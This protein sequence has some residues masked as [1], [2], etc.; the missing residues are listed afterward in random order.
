MFKNTIPKRQMHGEEGKNKQ[1]KKTRGERENNGT[2]GREKR[3][4]IQKKKMYI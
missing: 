1:T 4:N 3:R 2:S